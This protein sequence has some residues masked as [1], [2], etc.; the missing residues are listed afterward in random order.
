MENVN[1]VIR[2]KHF[3]DGNER[4]EI[5]FRLMCKYKEAHGNCLVPN[6]YKDLPQL[7][8]WVSTQRSH[9]KALKAGDLTSLTQERVDLLESIGFVWATR[10]P[11]HVSLVTGVFF[12]CEWTTFDYSIDIYL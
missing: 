7:G 5:M 2:L 4:W 1:G 12:F 9:Y 6:R 10:D 8:S 11:R 3:S